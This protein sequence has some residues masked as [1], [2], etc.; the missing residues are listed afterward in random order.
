MVRRVFT[1]FSG[2]GAP[3]ENATDCVVKEIIKLK[4]RLDAAFV[5]AEF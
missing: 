1:G 5:I 3:E 4:R 2:T